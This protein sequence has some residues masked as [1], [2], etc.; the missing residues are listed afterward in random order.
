MGMARA[1]YEANNFGTQS[2]ETP[3][4]TYYE[5]VMDALEQGA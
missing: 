1:F 5:D 3:V 4:P 2:V